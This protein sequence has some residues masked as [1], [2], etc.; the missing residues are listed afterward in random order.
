MKISLLI[1]VCNYDLIALVHSMKSEIGKVPEFHEIIIGNDASSQEFTD[2]Y[3]SLEGDGVKI[4]SSKKNIG[5]AAM[6]NKLALE[7]TGDYLLFLDADLMLIGTAEAFLKKYIKKIGKA[8][9]IN[10]G[11]KYSE[12]PPNDPDRL[13]RWK[14]GKWR[15]QRKASERNKRPYTDFSTFNILIAKSVFSKVR[16]YEE[17]K[18]YGY[19][20]TLLSFQLKNAGINILH[21]DNNL[22]HE[23]IES[24]REYLDK[25]KLSLENLSMLYDRVTDKKRFCGI[26]T[27]LRHYNIIR[28]VRAKLIFAKFFIKFKRKM[29]LKLETGKSPNWLFVLYRMSMFCAF[30]E[31]H[32]RKKVSGNILII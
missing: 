32:K 15:E 31:I 24:N 3:R 18:Q 11:I 7:A 8:Q 25:V 1:P 23:G 30:R 17:L 4:I 6:R 12:S 16:F 21:I 26:L 20:D 2:K 5:R 13:L 10:G 22:I 14:Y 9:V 28:S 29:E 19:E 27:T